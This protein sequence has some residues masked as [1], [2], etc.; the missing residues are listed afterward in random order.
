ML[1]NIK[2]SRDALMESEELAWEILD[3]TNDAVVL[4]DT[5]GTILASNEIAASRFNRSLEQMI[6]LYY[7]D[8][9]STESAASLKAHVTEI[10]KT[11]KPLHYEDEPEDKI[12]E[13][14]VFPV[15]GHRGDISRIAIFSRD[16]TM[17]KWVE[18]VTE[19]LGRRNASI[20][21]SAG[22]GIF[23]LDT[24]G[25]TTFVNPSGARML[26][27]LPEELKGKKHHDIVHHSK[28]DGK[29][30]PY[31]MC[32]I[33]ATFKDGNNHCNIDNEVFW[34]KDGSSFQVEYSSTPIIE[35]GRVLGAVV[36]FRDISDRKRLEKAL[37][38]SEEKYR[39]VIESTASLVVWLDRSG[40]IIDSNSRV[41]Q[42]LGYS[43]SEIIGRPFKN[44]IHP[45]YR[46][47]VEDLFIEAIS[48][49][50][51]HDYHI[52]LVTNKDSYIEVSMNIGIAHDASG[53]YAYTICM[54]SEANLRV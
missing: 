14:D 29:L 40:T 45:E 15:F 18:D 19:Q 2:R 11:Q 17:R 38:E 13:H 52:R 12:I 21:E 1:D 47:H 20:L 51:E 24:E 41:E 23:G 16:I 27:Y 7:Y 26:G 49:A 8:L 36:T 28:P 43:R 48:G 9:L 30:Y 31:E 53:N 22:E 3:A 42:L 39:S 5:N 50:S 25:R 34:R 37:R 10:L 32:P 46:N 44:F 54:I 35:N 6:D 4:I 33:Y